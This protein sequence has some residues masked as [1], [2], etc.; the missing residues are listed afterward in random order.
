MAVLLENW[1]FLLI[2]LL[3]DWWAIWFACGRSFFPTALLAIGA[4]T[5]SFSAGILLY[6]RIEW[7]AEQTFFRLGL[8]DGLL[9]LLVVWL[10]LRLTRPTQRL[11]RFDMG[12]LVLANLASL[13]LVD[14]LGLSAALPSNVS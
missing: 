5:V 1:A 10:A 12:L 3:V 13:L 6:P 8:A 9:E 11:D 4:N 14:I 7:F 2:V